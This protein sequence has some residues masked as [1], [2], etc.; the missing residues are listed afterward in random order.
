MIDQ[1]SRRQ[2]ESHISLLHVPYDGYFLRLKIFAVYTLK[3]FELYSVFPIF[4]TLLDHRK[5]Q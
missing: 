2:S 5:F 4:S 1:H 3:G